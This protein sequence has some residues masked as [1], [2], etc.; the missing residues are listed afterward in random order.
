MKR[1][2][3]GYPADHPRADLLRFAGMGVAR[4]LTPDAINTADLIEACVGD[5]IRMKPLIQWLVE[6]NGVRVHGR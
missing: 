2:P 1:V 5:A 6:L 3:R 4:L